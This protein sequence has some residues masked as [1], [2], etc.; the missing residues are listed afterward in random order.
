[1]VILTFYLSKNLKPKNLLDSVLPFI[2][3]IYQAYFCIIVKHSV[4][5]N[6]YVE[7][8]VTDIIVLILLPFSEMIMLDNCHI[9]YVLFFL[10]VNQ[11]TIIM[12]FIIED[13]N[14][15]NILF[16]VIYSFF[17]VIF[18]VTRNLISKNVQ[19]NLNNFQVINNL[20]EL[21][22][23]LDNMNCFKIKFQNKSIKFLNGNFEEFLTNRFNCPD[24]PS[25]SDIKK[26]L[27]Y[28]NISNYCSNKNVDNQKHV[29]NSLFYKS[30]DNIL[31]ID[32]DIEKL[33]IEAEKTKKKLV[34]FLPIKKL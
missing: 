33:R 9:I 12:F 21:K 15:V 7:Y 25:Q 19:V 5:K 27:K 6:K 18:Y 22:S 1:M 28:N 32:D 16:L 3:S 17:L 4:N 10:I 31:K 8:F 13:H 26:I 20:E 11:I 34:F 23:I 30:C 29:N 2:I 24:L 14:L